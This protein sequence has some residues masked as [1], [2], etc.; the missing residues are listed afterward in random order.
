MQ[1]T[2][3]LSMALGGVAIAAG[4]AACG[5]GGGGGGTV[6]QVPVAASVQNQV[7]LAGSA[8]SSTIPAY[9][10]GNGDALTYT[11]TKGDGSALPTGL[12]FNAATRTFSGTSALDVST[13]VTLKVTAT[14]TSA[15]SASATFTLSSVAPGVFKTANQAAG[16]LFY[17]VVFPVASGTA[18]VWTWEVDTTQDFT[19]LY[20]SQATYPASSFATAAAVRRVTSSAQ[21]WTSQASK[22]ATV[23]RAEGGQTFT[24]DGVPYTGTLDTV[25]WSG[26]N[27]AINTN[28]WQGTWILKETVSNIQIT[29]VWTIDAN[30]NISGTKKNGV[31]TLCTTTGADTK[32]TLIDTPVSRLKVT[33]DCTASSGA[34]QVYQGISFNE[35]K[36]D[37]VVTNKAM[38]MA[39]T[40]G[41]P[42]SSEFI[43]KIFCRSNGTT[44][45]P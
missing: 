4:L 5:G 41:S 45:T 11:A 7:V 23:A 17:G 28:D 39:R 26:T 19:R 36:V 22:T 43:T 33:Y 42:A 21:Q 14:D 30:G 35:S 38:L 44:C 25:G 27:A 10:D 13:P 2:K 29:H 6:N 24:V 9:T 37:G 1:M 15:T 20:S 8:F 18:E 3:K 34:P 32:V 12:S 31:N 16:T 40:D